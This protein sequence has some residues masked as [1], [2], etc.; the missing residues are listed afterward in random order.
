MNRENFRA[1]KS[2][3]FLAV[4]IAVVLACSRSPGLPKGID[5][6]K[7]QSVQAQVD[8]NVEVP[9]YLPLGLRLVG[10]EV[11]PLA[12]PDSGKETHISFFA[13]PDGPGLQFSQSQSQGQ[14]E[15]A[16]SDQPY[17]PVTVRGTPGFLY[18]DPYREGRTSLSLV[19][20]RGDMAYN[21]W[22]FLERGLTREMFL[23]IAESVQ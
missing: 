14:F 3:L 5:P 2:G 22:G 8:F 12:I 19:W 21:L 20:N 10:A 18:T 17:K 1:M 23:K 9:R 13:Y 6:A 11:L 15:L 7:L 4:L 16:M